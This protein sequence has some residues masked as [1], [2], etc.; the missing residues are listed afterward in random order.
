MI[1]C[2]KCYS[3]EIF[4]KDLALRRPQEEIA[5]SE[6]IREDFLGEVSLELG[7]EGQAGGHYLEHF[8]C[9]DHRCQRTGVN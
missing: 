9:K 2:G 1:G 5:S 4:Y 8:R 7:V 3:S 6:A